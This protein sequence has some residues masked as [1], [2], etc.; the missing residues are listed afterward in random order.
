MSTPDGTEF[1]DEAVYDCEPGFELRGCDRRICLGSGS[2]SGNAPMCDKIG[3]SSLR[4]TSK[5]F[6]KKLAT[7]KRSLSSLQIIVINI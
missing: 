4:E 6:Y 5:R 1:E 2:W 7:L 3:K